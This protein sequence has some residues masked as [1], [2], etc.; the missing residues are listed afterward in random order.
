MSGAPAGGGALARTPGPSELRI[1][2][3]GALRVAGAVEP[4]TYIMT[5]ASASAQGGRGSLA[6]SPEL[7]RAAR[8]AQ[9]VELTLGNGVI[10]R[11]K[12]TRRRGPGRGYF[13]Y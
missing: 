13:K 1:Q 9:D 5:N 3:A 6:G 8:L 7:L 4:V 10:M 2:G 11:I 12:I